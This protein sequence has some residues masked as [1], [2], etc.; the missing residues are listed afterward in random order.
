MEPL[1]DRYDRG[2]G[3]LAIG[4]F[5]GQVIEESGMRELEPDECFSCTGQPA[6]E[7]QVTRPA[8]L[9]QIA[10]DV[11]DI[12]KRQTVG[13]ARSMTERAA[14][15]EF[16]SGLERSLAT[17]GSPRSRNSSRDKRRR[18]TAPVPAA[19]VVHR[20]NANNWDSGD[21]AEPADALVSTSAA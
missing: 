1:P 18:C 20:I 13:H 4:A 12:L 15:H 17:V 6:K 7:H 16:A 8:L 21:L 10:S 19:N 2:S 14:L 3:R 11:G 5:N 9:R